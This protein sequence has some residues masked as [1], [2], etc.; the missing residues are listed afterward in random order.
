M[1]NCRR[2]QRSRVSSLASA[3]LSSAHWNSSRVLEICKSL[4]VFFFEEQWF[5]TFQWFSHAFVDTVEDPLPILASQR[6]SPSYF[7]T[8]SSFAKGWT[9]FSIWIDVW[10]YLYILLIWQPRPCQNSVSSYISVRGGGGL[11]Q[12]YEFHPL[13]EKTSLKWNCHIRLNFIV[14]IKIYN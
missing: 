8:K 2:D 3:P 14:E 11:Q 7:C 9:S 12:I 4:P 6:L 10:N 5:E 13:N 1:Q